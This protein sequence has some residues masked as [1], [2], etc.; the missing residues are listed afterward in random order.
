MYTESIVE[1]FLIKISVFNLNKQKIK[2]QAQTIYMI[3]HNMRD[4]NVY[5]KNKNQ[6][7]Y[8][9]HSQKIKI[10]YLELKNS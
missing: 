4:S 10:Y 2:V 5:A 6:G 9:I 7:F 1:T 8:I 3:T